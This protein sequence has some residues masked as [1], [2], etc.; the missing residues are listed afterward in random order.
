MIYLDYAATAPLSDVAKAAWLEATSVQGNASAIHGAGRA[1]RSILEDAREKIAS[2]LGV[3]AAEVIFTSGGTE[4]DN[5]AIAGPATKGTVLYSAIEHPAIQEAAD[6]AARSGGTTRVIPVTPDGVVDLNALADPL[7]ESVALVS[8]MAANNESGI[9][10]PLAEIKDLVAEKAP[11]ARLHTDAVQAISTITIPDGYA[12]TISGHKL[13]APVGIGALIAARDYPLIALEGGGGQERKVRSGTI[14]VAGAVALAAAL[15]DALA[16]KE[17]KA[18]VLAN[19]SAQIVAASEALGGY[20]SGGDV[21]R[22]PHITHVIFPG[23][24]PE[25]LL[26]GLDMAG[27][28]C[29]TGSACSAGVYRPS[30]VL[31][32]MGVAEDTYTA[33]RFST[34]DSTNQS[35][36]D[37]LVAAL[38]GAVN[39]ARKAART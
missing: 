13:G 26:L 9:I 25:A 22:L 18:R 10:Q 5:L 36:I 11:Q 1:S 39:M 6:I 17:E 19:F 38:P 2:L 32:A 27:I 16:K 31:E 12:I 29:S 14:N 7:D 4:A 34:G 21:P 35:E 37:A 8:V 20:R 28:S 15:E 24:D 23:T 3:D 33:L 30:T